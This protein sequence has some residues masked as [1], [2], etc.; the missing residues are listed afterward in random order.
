MTEQ[1]PEPSPEKCIAQ[2]TVCQ[3]QVSRDGNREQAGTRWEQA[4]VLISS[5][6]KRTCQSKGR[7]QPSLW[8]LKGKWVLRGYADSRS[9]VCREW[10]ASEQAQVSGAVS[11]PP[12]NI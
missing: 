1:R 8:A 10:H 12:D 4:F 2:L 9:L 5:S 6:A 11:L 3:L 7:N